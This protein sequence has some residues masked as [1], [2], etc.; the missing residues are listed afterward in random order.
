MGDRMDDEEDPFGAKRERNISQDTQ[1]RKRRNAAAYAMSDI[2]S[3]SREPSVMPEAAAAA[4]ERYKRSRSPVNRPAPVKPEPMKVEPQPVKLEPVKP[5]SRIP[6]SRSPFKPAPVKPEPMKV[7]PVNI[8]Q[9]NAARYGDRQAPPSLPRP[10]LPPPS[11][12]P[13]GNVAPQAPR[14]GRGRRRPEALIPI[15]EEPRQGGKKRAASAPVDDEVT[16]T[17]VK[18]NNSTDMNF[19]KEQSANEMRAQLN[20]RFP[21]QRGDWAFKDRQQLIYI[22]EVKI[23]DGDWVK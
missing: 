19:W 17:G 18:L 4:Q 7:E 20:L 5:E 9:E 10:P 14:L 6:R 16:M 11:R 8:K 23:R 13:D 2:S 12:D 21:G 1:D 15:A 22:I 3:M